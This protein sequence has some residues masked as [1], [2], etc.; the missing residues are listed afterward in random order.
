MALGLLLTLNFSKRQRFV[1]S[2]RVVNWARYWSRW[3]RRGCRASRCSLHRKESK[4][5]CVRRDAT[6][7]IRI[8]L[9]LVTVL[10][11]TLMMLARPGSAAACSCVRR[12]NSEEAFQRA[13]ALFRGTV[14][15]VE[16]PSAGDSNAVTVRVRVSTSWRGP[17]G[18]Q[19]VVYTSR[20]STACGY[21]F[22]I[23]VEYLI[24][25]SGAEDRLSKN[26][27][28]RT[29]VYASHPDRDFL[30]EGTPVGGAP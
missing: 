15:A 21:D 11:S 7:S 23:G 6:K 10:T 28:A 26:T 24:Y 4:R 12:E 30:G 9:L 13:T 1:A 14:T 20:W 19:A 5:L 8:G 29:G 3:R 18:P 2:G 17:I 25:A 16:M 27:C 22:A